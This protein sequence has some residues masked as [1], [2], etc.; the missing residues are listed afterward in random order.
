M[1]CLCAHIFN[2]KYVDAIIRCNEMY[3]NTF[4]FNDIIDFNNSNNNSNQCIILMK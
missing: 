4:D 3:M 1:S 2:K